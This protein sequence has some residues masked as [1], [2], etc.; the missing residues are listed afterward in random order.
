MSKI[1]R[2]DPC[3]CGSGKKYKKCCG[4]NNVIEFNPSLYNNELALVNNDLMSFAVSD[5]ESELM[6]YSNDCAVSYLNGADKDKYHTYITLLSAWT[7]L[8][9]Q[10]KNGKTIFDMFYAKQKSK[11]HPRTRK[12]LSSWIN[13][14]PGVFEIISMNEAPEPKMTL[15]DI[16]TNKTYQSLR[17]NETE[18]DIGS[19]AIGVLVP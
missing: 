14:K 2:N 3:P 16:H 19:L 18:K 12:V 17:G 13:V 4:G 10:M 7:I 11:L 5:F 9:K 15:H 8:K 6:E 1:G